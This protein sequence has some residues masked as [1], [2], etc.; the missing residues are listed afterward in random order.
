MI[1]H[2]K[3][4]PFQLLVSSLYTESTPL[5]MAMIRLCNLNRR[6]SNRDF[7]WFNGAEQ[8]LEGIL[9][10]ILSCLETD[11]FLVIFY[12]RILERFDLVSVYSRR[13]SSATLQSYG[14]SSDVSPG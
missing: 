3:N 9:A 10:A 6:C 1:G 7:R 8:C 12:S 5:S 14:A 4:V 2:S 13:S 11:G